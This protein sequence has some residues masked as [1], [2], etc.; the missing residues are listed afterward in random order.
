[1]VGTSSIGNFPRLFEAI[2]PNLS[3]LSANTYGTGHVPVRWE[4]AAVALRTSYSQ[5]RHAGSLYNLPEQLPLFWRT[6]DR[7][8]DLGSSFHTQDRL[9][10]SPSGFEKHTHLLLGGAN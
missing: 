6:A 4:R 3:W 9:S 7:M 10:C 5:A 2:R 8:A 1:M